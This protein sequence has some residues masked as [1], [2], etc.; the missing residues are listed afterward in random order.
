MQLVATGAARMGVRTL[1][2]CCSLMVP[3]I[4][5]TCMAVKEDG[6]DGAPPPEPPMWYTKMLPRVYS[7]AKVSSTAAEAMVIAHGYSAGNFVC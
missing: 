1:V 5:Q 3:D 2:P 6:L 7:I 4:R